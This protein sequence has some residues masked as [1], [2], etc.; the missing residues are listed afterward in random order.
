MHK[1]LLVAAYSGLQQKDIGSGSARVIQ[2]ETDLCDFSV[3]T[4]GTASDAQ[5]L[6]P[7]TTSPTG[8]MFTGL[9]APPA[10]TH[11]HDISFLSYSSS[12]LTTTWGHTLA[13]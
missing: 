5:V 4:G 13:N 1:L 9:S 11:T 7:P 2:G 3:S 6:D 10:N 8:T 12:A